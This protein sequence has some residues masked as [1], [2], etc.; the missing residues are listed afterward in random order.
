M[1]RKKTLIIII[2]K[3]ISLLLHSESK[4]GFSFY[5]KKFLLVEKKKC[6]IVKRHPSGVEKEKNVLKTSVFIITRTFKYKIRIYAFSR[7]KKSRVSMLEKS[8]CTRAQCNQRRTRC[9]R[10]EYRSRRASPRPSIN[11]LRGFRVGGY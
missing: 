1:T 2:V 8:P 5:L 10:V 7:L 4:S 3:A 11:M 9:V 6:F